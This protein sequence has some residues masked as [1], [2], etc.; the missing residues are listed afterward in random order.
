MKINKK[1][2]I[3]QSEM[4]LASKNNKSNTLARKQG[5]MNFKKKSP[6]KKIIKVKETALSKDKNLTDLFKIIIKA[7]FLH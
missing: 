3:I 7:E 4:K 5:W 6:K 1:L 2:W